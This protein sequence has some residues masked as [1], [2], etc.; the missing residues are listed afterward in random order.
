MN[1]N[2][3]KILLVL[4]V[5]YPYFSFCQDL[6]ELEDKPKYE[7]YYNDDE[8][9]D[10]SSLLKPKDNHEKLIFAL[11][12]RLNSSEK[13]KRLE[14]GIALR[15]NAKSSDVPYLVSNLKSGNNEDMQSFILETLGDLRDK[16]SGEALRFEI[17][18]GATSSRRYAVAALG[19]LGIDWAIPILTKV[20]KST[21]DLE[22]SM[23]AATA[24]GEIGSTPALYAIKSN[25]SNL[26]KQ[27]NNGPLNAALWALEVAE[28][29]VD[30]SLVDSEFE[31]GQVLTKY[32]N[33]TRYYFYYP[34]VLPKSSFIE[35]SKTYSPWLLVCIH[36]IDLEADTLYQECLK[37]AKRFQ[38]ALLVP[39][40][41]NRLFPEY[42]NF[43]IRE[44]RADKRL[45]EIISHISNNKKL[46]DNEIYIYGHGRGGDFV[47]R[48][49]LSYP[50][51]IARAATSGKK[52]LDFTK[53]EMFPNGFDISPLTPDIR[54]DRHK[55]IKSNL[56][57]VVEKEELKTSRALKNLLK[58][59]EL[60]SQS[61]GL[62]AR[63]A[64]RTLSGNDT[65]WGIASKYL[66]G[67]N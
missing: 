51:K 32:F 10:P 23:R 27:R 17:E 43:N 11:M 12:N 44:M 46:N 42:Y 58:Q 39:V 5:S 40:F 30:L 29:K 13:K 18:K 37:T 57:F 49:V 50:E 8:V 16:R 9:V 22:L 47:E 45:L 19:K 24:L 15:A 3:L 66:F 56:V 53:G 7:D 41:D 67:R 61:R 26:E 31:S 25:I 38:T 6:K 28:R 63:L 64:I 59:V 34:T 20:L 62:F 52:Y 2:L 21:S 60:Y 14:A 1:V 65:F 4:T 36:D 33:G 54:P 55:F 48:F 35:G